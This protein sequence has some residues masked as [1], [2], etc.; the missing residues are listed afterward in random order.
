MVK[1]AKTTKENHSIAEVYGY[2]SKDFKKWGKLG[3]RS[4]KYVS[5]A[6]KKQAYR[7]RKAQKKL[8][9]L[10]TGILSQ[11]TGRISQYRSLAEK[12]RAYRARKKLINIKN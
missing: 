8:F 7:R 5:E 10:G 1:K 12:K 4:A 6:E 9:D 3:G 11:K 2:K